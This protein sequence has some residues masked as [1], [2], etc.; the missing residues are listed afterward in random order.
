ME[1]EC[2]YWLYL[3]INISE[4]RLILLDH[5]T[6]GKELLFY[7]RST[8][9]IEVQALT[10]HVRGPRIDP[11]QEFIFYIQTTG[12]RIRVKSVRFQCSVMRN[13]E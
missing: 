12:F 5:I 6:N 2:Y 3:K 1:I 9:H 8:P 10:M 4:F 13:V 11:G 7:F